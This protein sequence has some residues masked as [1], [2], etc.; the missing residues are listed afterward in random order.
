MADGQIA[1]KT[2]REVRL[3]E[4][5]PPAFAVDEVA[6]EFELSPSATIVRASLAMRRTGHGPLVLD[7]EGLTLLGVKLDGETLG[8]N[9]YELGQTALTVA[10]VP[11]AFTLETEVR[12]AP[13]RN[14]AL[15]GLYMSGAGFFTQCEPEGF[16]RITYF[17]DRPDVMARYSVTVRADK[18]AYPVLLSN[19]NRIAGGEGPAGT[20]WARWDDPHPKPSYLFALV[21]ADL[22]AVKDAFTTRS[23]RPVELGIYVAA[24]DES[25][26]DTPW[27]R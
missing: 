22:V 21:A 4:Y 8:D 13:D 9:R 15:S 2:V 16:R 7:G 14:T 10:D 6:L 18:A 20:H 5:L 25:G 3:A 11:D 27:R 24:G 12:I 17:P 23:G 26:S 1:P 19:G